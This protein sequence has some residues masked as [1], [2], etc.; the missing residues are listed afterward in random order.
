MLWGS[1]KILNTIEH[2]QQALQNIPT[3]LHILTGKCD[4]IF[5]AEGHWVGT[6]LW[7]HEEWKITILIKIAEILKET[8][9]P[10]FS[11]NTQRILE[12]L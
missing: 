10:K 11:K 4:H 12:N 7:W 1:H 9:Y 3:Y 5:F 6:G 2:V 8:M